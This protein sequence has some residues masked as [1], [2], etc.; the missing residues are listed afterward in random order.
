MGTKN[1]IYNNTDSIRSLRYTNA[2]A[3]TAWSDQGVRFHGNTN[4]LTTEDFSG[5]G[6]PSIEYTTMYPLK[7]VRSMTIL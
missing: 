4:E 5:R 2:F 1:Q 3:I 6:I 7:S